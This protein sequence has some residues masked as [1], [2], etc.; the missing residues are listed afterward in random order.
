[1]RATRASQRRPPQAPSASAE[2]SGTARSRPR[3]ARSADVRAQAAGPAAVLPALG[4]R[5][6]AAGALPPPAT[7]RR[8][9]RRR[10]SSSFEI[11]L[12]K[13]G[14]PHQRS[15]RTCLDGAERDAEEL[16]DLALGK[17]APV[18]ERDHLALALRQ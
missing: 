14:E 8:R 16:G 5:A 9:R 10:R 17:A 13:L 18:R 4:G 15:A 11:L 3:P 12:E 2:A 6:R 7:G 1:M